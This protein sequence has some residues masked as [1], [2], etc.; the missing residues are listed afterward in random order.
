MSANESQ[1]Q[2]SPK[3][4]SGQKD[5]REAQQELDSRNLAARRIK[6]SKFGK[7]ILKV[8]EVG[9]TLWMWGNLVESHVLASLILYAM[10]LL[11]ADAFA[12]YLTY[13][14][15]KRFK[16]SRS[17]CIVIWIIVTALSGFVVWNNLSP[18]NLAAKSLGA[19][20]TQTPTL[21]DE[22][23]YYSNT[24]QASQW[25][26]P[27]LNGQSAIMVRFGGFGLAEVISG[28]LSSST[29]EFPPVIASNGIGVVIPYIKNNR[30]YLKSQTMFGD[31]ATTVQMNDE[32]PIHL[33]QGWDR[34]FNGNSFEIVD[35]KELP[36]FQV[37][38]ESANVID[39]NGI[40]VA[41]DGSINVGFGEEIFGAPAGTAA[42]IPESALDGRK[43]WF[44][45]PSRQFQGELVK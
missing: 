14:V 42:K 25:K 9:F 26:P 18:P 16:W 19:T 23:N 43:V 37:R 30:L 33:P 5:G 6:K 20:P 31:A 27:E 4:D 34:N 24:A 21:Q 32:W 8:G 35:E 11:F 10:G 44:K 15:F 1:N 17:I 45:Y 28:N 39:V 29:G 12:C 41:P 2:E 3:D 38:Y 36:V 22:I 13:R 7:T 40:F